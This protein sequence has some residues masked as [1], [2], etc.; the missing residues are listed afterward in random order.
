MPLLPSPAVPLSQLILLR[1][2][3]R[4]DAITP[5]DDVQ[6]LRQAHAA[7]RAPAARLLLRAQVL[8]KE[9]G[10]DRE[11]AAWRARLVWVAL[12]AALGVGLLSYGLVKAVVGDDRQINAVAA[13]LAVLGPHLLSLACGCCCS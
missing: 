12:A 8:A 10:L 5:L 2:V 13:L 7:E 9:K 4:L 11:L 6:A 1:A 3:Q